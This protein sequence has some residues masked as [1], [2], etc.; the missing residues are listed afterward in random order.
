MII[1]KYLNKFK[2]PNIIYDKMNKTINCCPEDNYEVFASLVKFEKE[3]HFPSKIV[4]Y[5]KNKTCEIKMDVRY[6]FKINK[7]KG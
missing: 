1:M 7:Y 6:H 3:K 2:N 5:N 4:K